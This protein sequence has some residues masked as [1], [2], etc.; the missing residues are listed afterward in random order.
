M[1]GHN[2]IFL[3]N[4]IWK[5]TVYNNKQK[6]CH[7]MLTELVPLQVTIKTSWW[8]IYG[9][10]TVN[11]PK[12]SQTF[13]SGLCPT[14][15]SGRS[16]GSLVYILSFFGSCPSSNGAPCLLIGLRRACL[17]CGFH[18]HSRKRS[19]PCHHCGILPEPLSPCWLQK[20]SWVGG[21]GPS[22][23]TAH[24]AVTSLRLIDQKDYQVTA[25]CTF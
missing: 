19:L 22:V 1:K 4:L 21:Q 2:T 9:K 11:D 16:Q 14:N 8:T 17:L 10:V 25:A 20:C 23:R 24:P 3:L 5:G 7:L 15:L 6:S 18:T 12:K 13:Y